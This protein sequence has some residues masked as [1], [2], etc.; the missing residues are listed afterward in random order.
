MEPNSWIQA[1][2]LK[3]YGWEQCSSA[4]WTS[5]AQGCARHPLG[6][7][8]SL[9][10]LCPSSMPFPWALLCP[11]RAELSAAPLLT[12]SFH[13]GVNLTHTHQQSS[14]SILFLQV[15]TVGAFTVGSSWQSSACYIQITKCL[16]NTQSL[17]TSVPSKTLEKNNGTVSPQWCTPTIAPG[18]E[19]A[20]FS[21]FLKEF[22]GSTQ[23]WLTLT[24][25]PRCPLPK[26]HKGCVFLP[27]SEHSRLND[28]VQLWLQAETLQWD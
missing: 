7:S 5:A 15:L 17:R 28:L 2:P 13:T 25:F 6:Q 22:L 1:T 8:F 9:T 19:A 23:N 11:Q 27:D 12:P 26:P 3:P 16:G 20:C 14:D 4:P 24:I 21:Q 18:P 10:L